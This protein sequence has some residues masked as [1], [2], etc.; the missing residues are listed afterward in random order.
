MC[1]LPGVKCVVYFALSIVCFLNATPCIVA[2]IFMIVTSVLY[3]FSQVNYS[4]DAA[5]GTN[6]L[7]ESTDRAGLVRNSFGTF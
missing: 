7:G 4:T 5:D 3:G 6:N 2:G 1:K